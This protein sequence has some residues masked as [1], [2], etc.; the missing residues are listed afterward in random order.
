MIVFLQISLQPAPMKGQAVCLCLHPLVK[1]VASTYTIIHI[2]S[3]LF[4]KVMRTFG[5]PRNSEHPVIALLIQTCS[6][7]RTYKLNSLTEQISIHE[8]F[9]NFIA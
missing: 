9:L 1:P 5:M 3:N 6:V 4:Q 2:S 7:L 8:H